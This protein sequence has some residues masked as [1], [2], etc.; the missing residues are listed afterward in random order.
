MRLWTLRQSIGALLLADTQLQTGKCHRRPESVGEQEPV[1][2]YDNAVDIIRS[3]A[4][5]ELT[6]EWVRSNNW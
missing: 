4:I 2:A 3:Y 5:A 1:V 6:K